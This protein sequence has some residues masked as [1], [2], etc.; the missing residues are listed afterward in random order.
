[1]TQTT[2]KPSYRELDNEEN[3]ELFARAKAANFS[4]I[5]TQLAHS[6]RLSKPKRC[7]STFNVVH[8]QMNNSYDGNGPS[9]IKDTILEINKSGSKPKNDRKDS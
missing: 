3:Q 1:M 6:K 5:P 2:T 4:H 9:L 8:K 7:I